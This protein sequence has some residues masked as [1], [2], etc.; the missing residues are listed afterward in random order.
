MSK[1][2]NSFVLFCKDQREH[3]KMLFPDKTNSEIKSMLCSK[4]K[5]LN[6]AEKQQYIDK[7]AGMRKVC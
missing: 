7:A 3:H 1:R 5:N 6:Q 4:W 2:Y